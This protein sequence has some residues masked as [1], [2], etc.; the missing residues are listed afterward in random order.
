MTTT[1]QPPFNTMLRKF[2]AAGFVLEDDQQTA[3][4]SSITLYRNDIAV[5]ITQH[6]DRVGVGV[7]F[8]FLYYDDGSNEELESV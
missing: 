2:I 5:R 4:D 3:D 8:K 1:Q 6:P 7:Q